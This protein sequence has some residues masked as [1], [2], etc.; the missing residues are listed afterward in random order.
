M[1]DPAWK[2]KKI[3]SEQSQDWSVGKTWNWLNSNK[4]QNF[5]F[6]LQNFFFTLP[7]TYTLSLITTSVLSD[8]IK[9]KKY[10][11]LYKTLEKLVYSEGLLVYFNC[12][13]FITL[14]FISSKGKKR[15]YSGILQRLQS[16]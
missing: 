2:K 5:A 6:R 14:K 13:F 10:F 11:F 9:E 8:K 15:E 7:G 1:E 3:A 4:L 12:L 16:K